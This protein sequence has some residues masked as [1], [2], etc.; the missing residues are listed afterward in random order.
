MA[1]RFSCRDCSGWPFKIDVRSLNAAHEA[2]ESHLI[3][4][5]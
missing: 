4:P 1:L 2:P 5:D 3:T